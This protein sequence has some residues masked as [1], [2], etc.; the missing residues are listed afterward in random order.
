MGQ[1]IGASTARGEHPKDRPYTRAA[2][3]EHDL[4]RDGHRPGDDLPQRQPAGRCTSSTTASRSRNCW[5]DAHSATQRTQAPRTCTSVRLDHTDAVFY[6][7][8]VRGSRLTSSCLS[9][10]A[11]ARRTAAVRTTRTR[12]SGKWKMESMTAEGRQGAEASDRM[13]MTSDHGVH[14]R[15]EHQGRDGRRAASPP[16]FKADAGEDKEAAGEDERDE[17]SRAS[18]RSP[19]TRSSSRTWKKGRDGSPFGKNNQG[20]TEVRRRR[21]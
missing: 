12:S 1:A 7:A 16:E 4:P 15:R 21:L 9:A 8:A 11:V 14:R 18:T 20:E 3:A 5:A 10:S 2:G 6:H 19:V 17:A 13:G